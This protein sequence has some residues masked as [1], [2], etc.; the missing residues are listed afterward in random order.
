[1]AR[2]IHQYTTDDACA[3]LAGLSANMDYRLM[4]EVTPEEMEMLLE[5][6]WRRFGPA[7]F[8]PVCAACAEC[9]SLRIP[10][11]EF[12]PTKSQRRAARKCRGLRIES[13]VPIVN[14]ER[15]ALYAA[16]HADREKARGWKP[17]AVDADDYHFSFCFA[18]PCARELAYYDGDR[19]VAVD[20]VDETPRAL[21][22]IY[23]YYHPDY[24]KF[25]LGIASVL[26]EIEWARRLGLDFVYLGYRVQGCPSVAYKEQFSPHELLASRPELDEPTVWVMG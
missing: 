15:L 13:G 16:W 6:G 17:N 24:A 4:I 18:H 11:A 10:V 2:L 14:D 3:Y 25:S 8:R 5:R 22:S 21:S 26:F 23:F 12:Q 20:L 19:L 7:Y 1:M 9:V